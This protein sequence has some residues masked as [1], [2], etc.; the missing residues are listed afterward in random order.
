MGCGAS[1]SLQE[2][3]VVPTTKPG[4]AQGAAV[5]QAN[6]SGSAGGTASASSPSPSS[7]RADGGGA[8]D[9]AASGA[10]ADPASGPLGG[11]NASAGDGGEAA[12][13]ESP[14]GGEP[15]DSEVVPGGPSSETALKDPSAGLARAVVPSIQQAS[16]SSGT[17]SRAVAFEIPLDESASTKAAEPNPAVRAG[18]PKLGIDVAAKLAN[19]EARWKDLDE[20]QET[21]RTAAS[22]GG[23]RAKPSLTSSQTHQAAADEDP[24]ALRR[25]LLEKEAH[26]AQ[27]RL[28]EIEKLQAKLARQEDRSRRVLQRKRLLE[29]AAAAASTGAGVDTDAVAATGT[30]GVATKTSLDAVADTIALFSGPSPLDG[31]LPSPL[32][33]AARVLEDADS[34]KGSSRSGS[35]RSSG[36]QAGADQAEIGIPGA[37]A[38]E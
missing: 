9:A 7:E 30:T 38:V 20:A 26:A 3:A 15:S 8:G 24:L 28:R 27:N 36:N 21:R 6:G 2:Q 12:G 32:A 17:V 22:Q 29:A 11:T 25:R 4:D 37:L 33:K 1:K 14:K 23:R 13:G 31:V 5:V 10:G 16:P 18:L 34:G 19:A 35:G